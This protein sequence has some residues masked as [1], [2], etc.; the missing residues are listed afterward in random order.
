MCPFQE[1]LNGTR[2]ITVTREFRDNDYNP[3]KELGG[4]YTII[5]WYD[6]G[7]DVEKYEITVKGSKYEPFRSRDMRT[8]GVYVKEI[9]GASEKIEFKVIPK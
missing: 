3:V 7:V 1:T 9:I 5:L 2:T 8:V 4:D 6:Q